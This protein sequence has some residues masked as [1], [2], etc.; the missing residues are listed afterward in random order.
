MYSERRHDP[1]FP[2]MTEVPLPP[3]YRGSKLYFNNSTRAGVL[4]CVEQYKICETEAGPCWNNSNTTALLAGMPDENVTDKQLAMILVLLALDYSS[5][6]GSV[7]FR[8]AEALD[9]QSK[10]AH[11]QS[12]PLATE[13]WR[14][15]AEKWFQTSLAR[16]QLN[17]FD[18]ARGTAASFDGYEDTLFEQYRGICDMVKIPTVGWTNVNF[19]VSIGTIFAVGILWFIGWK[20]ENEHKQKVLMAAKIWEAMIRPTCYFLAPYLKAILILLWKAVLEC[21]LEPLGDFLEILVSCRM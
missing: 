11:M 15:E 20:W 17:V 8:G 6:C 10:V 16:M 13:Q 19:F 1:I 14:V 3:D 4:G 2:A 12:L 18:I 21:I 5:T 7:Q 9:A